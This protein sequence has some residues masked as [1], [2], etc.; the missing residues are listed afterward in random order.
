MKRVSLENNGYSLHLGNSWIFM[1]EILTLGEG[2]S[3]TLLLDF[4]AP[5]PN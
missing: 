3:L 4:G 1:W 5:F 2:L